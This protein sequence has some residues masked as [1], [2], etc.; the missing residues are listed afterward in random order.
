MFLC[1]AL[2]DP[3]LRLERMKGRPPGPDRYFRVALALALLAHLVVAGLD[4]RFGWS[5]PIN[6][7]LRLS[8]LLL[9]MVGTGLAVSA[10]C[11]NRFSPPP[12]ASSPSAATRSSPPAPIG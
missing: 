3:D 1:Y 4:I 10:M 6:T 9:Y 5:G 12:S 11:V 8:G 7:P 2:M